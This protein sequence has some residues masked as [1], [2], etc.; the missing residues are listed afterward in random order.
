MANVF[1]YIRGDVQALDLPAYTADAVEIGDLMYWDATTGAARPAETVAGANYAAK[2]L[3]LAASFL[4]VAM[5]AKAANQPGNVLVA[6]TGDFLV[7]AP[8][9]NGTDYTVGQMLAGGSGTAMQD[10]GVAPTTNAAECIGVAT[11]PK[12]TAQAYVQMRLMSRMLN[13]QSALTR[14]GANVI[15]DLPTT[16]PNV[17]GALWVDTTDGRV[18]KSSAGT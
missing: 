4:G 3:N 18:V 16:N 17:A 15:A 10:Q 6:T 2:K 7:G 12:T 11:A 13:V 14:V 5:T 8:S 9:G 1:R